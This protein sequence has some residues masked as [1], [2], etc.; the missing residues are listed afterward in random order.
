MSVRRMLLALVVT[1]PL[2]V[3]ACSDDPRKPAAQ[4]ASQA[5]SASPSPTASVPPFTF[6][7]GPAAGTKGLPITTEVDTRVT[8]GTVASVTLTDDK[9]KAVEGELR[10]DGSSWIPAKPLEFERTYS[11]TVTAKG[12]R[13]ESESK[14]TTFTTMARPGGGK[15]GS[16]LYLFNGQ[17]YGTAMPVVVEFESDVPEASRAAVARRLLVK[18]TPEQPGRWHWHSPRMVLYRAE[19]YWQP[20]TTISVR[21][22]LSGLP[23]GSKYGDTDRSATV[24]IAD[25]SIVIEVDNANKKMTV[26]KDGQP[27][28]ELPVSLGKPST[29]SS[30]GHM[31][32]MEKAEQTVFDTRATDGPNGYR[33]D[34]QYAQRLT[35]GGEY[36]HS[37]PWSVQQQGNTNVSHGCVNVSESNAQ[38]LF[39]LTMIGDAVIVKGTERTL[40]KG[41]GWTAWDIPWDQ[42]GV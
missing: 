15:V 22:A 27:I 41:N 8:G 33:V 37:A 12:V 26:L 2:G 9:G 28:K 11:A 19:K 40:Q 31:V 17:T 35:W 38:W 3:T 24:K 21:S 5:A 6:E 23:I 25:R 29:P 16:G 10:A 7:V 18:T 39:Q 20:G 1:L 30:S 32:V 14:N 42:Y 34:I 36:I 13:G 4:P